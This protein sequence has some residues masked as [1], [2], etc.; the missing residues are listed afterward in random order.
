MLG[1]NA[2]RATLAFAL[3]VTA[4]ACSASADEYMMPIGGPG[5]GRFD[6]HCSSDSLLVG[7][8]LRAADDVNAIRPLCATALGPAAI[9]GID[10][11]GW[12]GG[13]GGRPVNV[14]C[15]AHKPIVMG[16]SVHAEGMDTV[17]VNSIDLTC[18]LATSTQTMD[19][20][21]PSAFEYVRFSA[22]RIASYGSDD[23]YFFF[24]D[25][26]EPSR[27][28]GTHGCRDGLVAVGIHGRSGIWL[29]AIGLIC[30]EPRVAGHG[31]VPQPPAPPKKTIAEQATK[32]GITAAS[33]TA[34]ASAGMARST[35]QANRSA[36][37]GIMSAG[38]AVTSPAPPPPVV[39]PDIPVPVVFSPPL[40][41]DNAQLWACVDAAARDDAGA[42][43]SID[44]AQAYCRLRDAQSGPDLLV[45]DAQPGTP[46]R[47]V[48]GD[49]CVGDACQVVSSLQCDR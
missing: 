19:Y 16:L 30:G 10:E 45:T 17:V 6:G 13:S 36:A 8:E 43:S 38:Q 1:M 11:S 22:Q 21:H 44:S 3:F 48:N 12:H 40:L 5:G 46:V 20:R 7:F 2:K 33:K 9:G 31:H 26:D 35:A 37:S 29:D 28:S 25:E 32:T 23:Y 27:A 4:F 49:A 18:G 14:M 24:I 34:S 41:Q 15:P 42:C 39:A 47:A